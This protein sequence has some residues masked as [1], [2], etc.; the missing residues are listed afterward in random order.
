[1]LPRGAGVLAQAGGAA[2]HLRIMGRLEWTTGQFQRVGDLQVACSPEMA[3]QAGPGLGLRPDPPGRMLKKRILRVPLGLFAYLLLDGYIA[4]GIGRWVRREMKPE[5][6]FLDVGC[7]GMRLRRYL[8]RGAW[9]NGLDVTMTEFNCRRLLRSGARAN[10]AI[11]SATA[12][13]LPESCVDVLASTEV[14]DDIPDVDA[15]VRE[16]HRVARPGAR[17]LCSIPNT[18][19][20][21]YAR[22]GSDPLTRHQWTFE[23]FKQYMGGFG[24]Q[25]LEGRM[26]G[27]WVPLPR[28][29]GAWSYHLP[30]SPRSEF[31]NSTFL[32]RFEVRK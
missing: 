31:Y 8:P 15:A 19:C 28:W 14:L 3:S 17:F 32:Y 6:T 5:S 18:H 21:T 11:A 1:V 13:P 22:K 20:H 4:R 23:G 16:I 27:W 26:R 9:Y 25:C 29:V 2:Y 12:I 7:G 30:I 10:L 24:F